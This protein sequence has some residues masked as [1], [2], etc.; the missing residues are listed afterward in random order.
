MLLPVKTMY[1]KLW[2][3]VLD[4]VVS[5]LA[6]LVLSPLLAIPTIV[7]CAV[8]RGN[9]FFVQ[10]RPGKDERIFRLVKFRTMTNARDDR[11]ELLPDEARL[12]GY[13]RFL[14][15]T[16]LDELPELW[17]VLKGDMS[18]VGPRPL[19]VKYLPYYTE[20]ERKRHTIRPGITGWAQVN[21]RNAVEWSKRF[22]L[23]N[24]YVEHSGFIFDIKI[25]LLT[26]SKILRREN[27]AEN[28]RQTEG[29]FAEIRKAEIEA[30]HSV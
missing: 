3:R 17:N 2:K 28:T 25:I 29:N 4:F 23:D 16:S 26:V 6:L 27:I 1:G 5:L 22:A 10:P 11:G 24:E 9:P 15:S 20:E 12:N 8:M 7:G 19:L 30:Q 14:R 13:G 18:L 21:G